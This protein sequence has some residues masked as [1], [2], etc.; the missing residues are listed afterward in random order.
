MCSLLKS[1]DNDFTLS[2]GSED[3]EKES[4]PARPTLPDPYWLTNVDYTPQVSKFITLKIIRN[5]YLQHI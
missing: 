2:N 3:E 1:S 4:G 5:G